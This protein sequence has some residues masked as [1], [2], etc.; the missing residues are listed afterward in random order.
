MSTLGGPKVINEGMGLMLDPSNP[1][2]VPSAVNTNILNY[3][4]WQV[5][6][7]SATGFNRN[8]GSSENIIEAGTGPYGE[9]STLWACRNNT[10][11]SDSD[12]GWNTPSFSIDNTKLYRYTIWVYRPVVGN[13]SFYF[14]THG[15]GS[16]NGVYSRVNGNNYTNP[17]F[18]V[19]GGTGGGMNSGWRLFVGHMWPAGSGTGANHS[20]SGIYSTSGKIG[21]ISQD[22]VWRSESASGNYRTYLYYSTNSS[23]V[24]LFAYPRVDIVDG[25]EPTIQDLLDGENRKVYNPVNRSQ[26]F[27]MKNNLRLKSLKSWG[28]GRSINT[29]EFDGTND[30]IETD[31]SDDTSLKRTI[32]IVFKVTATNGTRM[33][34][35]CYTRGGGQ[36]TV[37]GKRIWLGI[38]SNKFQMHGWGTTDPA[39]TTNVNN[40]NYYHA[41][42]SYDQTTAK[43]QIW[44]NGVRENNSTDT[45]NNMTGWSNSSDHKWFVGGDPDHYSDFTSTFNGEIAIFRTYNRILSP[46]EIKINYGS[47]KRK[48]DLG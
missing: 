41:V 12:G 16:V 48:Y 34:I 9:A 37:S 10:A 1:K 29:F 18:Y 25:T 8:G 5:G 24:Q 3:R 17:Y 46:A 13:G 2:I 36:S 26:S 44:I 39:S 28:R 7:S 38:Q 33:P 30:I 4:T 6:N 21:S 32:E 19:S 14:G 15:Y 23:T 11:S 40:N 35:A 47:L 43:H 27:F 22:F 42:Y 45:Q 20:D 31:G